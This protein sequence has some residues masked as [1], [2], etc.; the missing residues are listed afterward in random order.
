MARVVCVLVSILAAAASAGAQ[1]TA[2][3]SIRGTVKDEGGGV[4]AGVA[5]TATSPTAPGV[6]STV[7]DKDGGYHLVNLP[8]AD[9]AIAADLMGFAHYVR[10]PITVLA[11]LNASADIV[12]K[13]GA[14]GETVDVRQEASLL[15]TR[16]GAQAVNLSGDLVNAMPL[17]EKREWYGSL[18]LAPGVTMADVLGQKSI[19]V[20]GADPSTTLIQLDGAD[21]TS[22]ARNGVTFLSL[23]TDAI[24]DIQIKTSGI[25]AS[26]PLGNGGVINIATVSGTNT[27]R[28]TATVYV[29]PEAWNDSNTPGGTSSD[30]EQ[31]QIDLSAG[32]PLVKDHLWAFGSYRHADVTTGVSHTAQQL[33]INRALVPDYQP[34]DSESGADLWF[35][36]L[37]AQLSTRH[38][39]VGFYQ[40]DFSTSNFVNATVVVPQPAV[41]GGNA[42]SVQ[43]S[44]VWS[45]RLTSRLS[46]AYNDKRRTSPPVD[47]PGPVVRIYD[48]VTRSGGR[49]VGTS[50]LLN[51]GQPGTAL[52]TSPNWKLSIAADA[53][54]LLQRGRGSHELQA[55]VYLQ[56]REQAFERNYINDGFIV[57][58]SALRRPGNFSSG[59]VPF[60]RQFVDGLEL[61][62]TDQRTNDV[63]LYIQDAWRPVPRLTIN[64][65]VRVDRVVTR[66]HV[67]DAMTQRSTE[68]GPRIGVNYALTS[69]ARHVARG[70]WVRVHDQ[71]GIVTTAASPALATTDRY[72]LDQDGTFETSFVTP[73]TPGVILNR[74]I[75]PDLHQPSVPEWGA[76]YGRHL[77]GSLT[78]NVDFVHRRFVDRATLV[79]TNGEYN[80]NVFA[81]Y[82]NESFNEIYVATNNRWNT[83]VYGALDF[84]VTKRTA[85][86]QG[87]ASYVRQWRHIDGTWQPHDP[88]SFIQ[89]SAFSNDRGIGNSTG[90]AS[91]T[92]DANSL[93]GVHMSEGGTGAAQWQ[94]HVVR[95]GLTYNGPWALLLAANY[96]YSSGIWGGPIVTRIAAPDPAFGPP[97][98]TLSNGRVVSNPLST[99]IRFAYPTRGDNQ[100]TT[101]DLHQLNVRIGRRFVLG[102]LKLDGSLDVFNVTN[103]DADQLFL[104]GANQT[105]NPLYGQLTSRQPPRSAQLVLRTMF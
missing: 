3:G 64:A 7:T 54:L 84:S 88:A 27:L 85:R 18:A 36:K 90:S 76:G 101:P 45:N 58:E 21:V 63:A 80:G 11:G 72:D 13:V 46:V 79:E 50:S 105:Y 93:S 56:P 69:D 25:D 96:T 38:Q 92:A 41:Q 37:T 71:P 20:H 42:T 94:D 22:A 75:D 95:L 47:V 44:S 77:G 28:A 53:T 17:F 65:G 81:G 57:E 19:F 74:S 31:T 102:R 60:H 32:G 104:A 4:L 35:G 29:Q 12:M 98:V 91:G 78:A 52:V 61:T 34:L 10:M 9:Y 39:L 86:L 99:T 68:V 82:A 67:V 5:V 14:I 100:Q 66:D 16:N 97:T 48:G 51:A 2:S 6:H 40:R 103:H 43:L 73:A 89:P 83:P 55:G 49:L 26:T 1:T 24:S 23:N 33:A 30:V 59:L 87:I 8:P 70:Y 15:E 62:T